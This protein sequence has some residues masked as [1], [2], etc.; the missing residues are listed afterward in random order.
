MKKKVKR[1][2]YIAPIIMEGDEEEE[3]NAVSKRTRL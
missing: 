1:K 2:R 3:E